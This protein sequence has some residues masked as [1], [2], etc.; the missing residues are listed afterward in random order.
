MCVCVVG[1]Y[2]GDILFLWNRGA[3]F[4]VGEIILFKNEGHSVPIVHRVVKVSECV[5]I[6][7]YIYICVCVC[8]CVCMYM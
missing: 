1:F 4:R 8:V 6:Y 5:Y 3:S 7:I 2:R